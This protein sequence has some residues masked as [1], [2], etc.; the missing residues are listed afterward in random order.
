MPV[1]LA[2]RVMTTMEV[3]RDASTR[4]IAINHEGPYTGR[5]RAPGGYY[6]HADQQLRF[7]GDRAFEFMPFML[8]KTVTWPA[9]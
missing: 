3:S 7:P 8:N 5:G 2:L 9:Y 4:A 6:S 1:P